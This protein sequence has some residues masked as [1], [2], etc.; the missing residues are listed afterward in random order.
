MRKIIDLK[1]VQPHFDDVASGRKKAELRKDDRDFAVGDMLILREWTGT[2][3][4]GRKISATITHILKDC[5]FGL[6]EGVSLC[7]SALFAIVGNIACLQGLRRVCRVVAWLLRAAFNR[8]CGGT[9]FCF[10]QTDT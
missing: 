8:T 3:Y 6:A 2:E 9:D 7:P 10:L 4:T 1:I 5:G